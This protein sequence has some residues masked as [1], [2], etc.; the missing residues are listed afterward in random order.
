[1]CEGFGGLE[2]GEIMAFNKEQFK[3]VIEK[4]LKDFH[5]R[6]YSEAAVNLLLG[7][8]AQESHFGTYLRQVHGPALGVFQ[9]EPKTALDIHLNFLN[10]RQPLNLRV[11]DLCSE[12]YYEEDFEMQFNLA[13]QIIMARLHY[14]RVKEPLPLCEDVW[15]MAK[16]WKRYY[17]TPKG[18]GT[19]EE[20]VRNYERFVLCLNF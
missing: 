3:S 9:M 15:G 17:N 6:L 18:K 7:T 2:R 12:K 16:Y 20:F 13:Y 19:Q 1:M 4:V 5:K 8:A 10:P 14:W 11:H